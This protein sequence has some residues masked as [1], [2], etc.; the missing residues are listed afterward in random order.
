MAVMAV[1]LMRIGKEGGPGAL[2]SR[3]YSVPMNPCDSMV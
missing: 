2:I 3:S 1:N